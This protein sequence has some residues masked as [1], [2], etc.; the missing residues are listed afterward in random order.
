MV[1]R[2]FTGSR[3]ARQ[4]TERYYLLPGMGGR[5]RQQK[6][7]QMVVWGMLA[8]LITSLVVGGVLYLLNRLS[9][10]AL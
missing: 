7:K 8:G 6:V 5:A 10:G 9:E 1:S 4:D 3:S 2:L